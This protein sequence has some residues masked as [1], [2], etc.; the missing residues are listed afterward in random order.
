MQLVAERVVE[1]AP[2]TTPPPLPPTKA[3][4][5][6]QLQ[7]EYIHRAAWKAGVLG[8]L[9]LATRILAVRMILMIAVIGAIALTFS[10]LLEHDMFR[11]IALGIYCAIVVVPV[12][13]L[14]ARHP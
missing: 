13:I 7:R 9:N 5:P 14:A 4:Q 1:D 3:P 6:D 10:A 11:L 2:A 8:A 12:V